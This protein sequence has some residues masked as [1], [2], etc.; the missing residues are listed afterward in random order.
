MIKFGDLY[1]IN[2]AWDSD[3]IL[4]IRLND[5]TSSFNMTAFE[6]YQKYKDMEVLSFS[7]NY[8]HLMWRREVQK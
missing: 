1:Q 4:N 7:G 3:T 8:V 2:L 5:I 6:V